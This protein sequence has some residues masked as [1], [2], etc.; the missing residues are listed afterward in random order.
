[1]TIRSPVSSISIAQFAPPRISAGCGGV[2]IFFGSFSFINGAQFEQL[3]RTIAANAVGYA[4]K[5]A[6][7]TMCDPCNAIIGELEK[8]VRELNSLAKNTCAVAQSM[9]EGSIATKMQEQ[10]RKIGT[11]LETAF[12]KA[13]DWLS[14]EN[15][16]QAKSDNS[17]ATGGDS[18]VVADNNPY[19][20]NLVWRAAQRSLGNG[21]NVLSA[22][23]TTAEATEFVMSLFGTVVNGQ[24][25]DAETA[26]CPQDAAPE[27]CVKPV[28]PYEPLITTWDKLFYPRKYTQSGV[29][30]YTCLNDDC[31]KIGTRTISLANWGG[32][33]YII[34]I[35]LF[36]S[37]NEDDLTSWTNNSL[38]GSYYSRTPLE[39]NTISPASAGL[40][41]GLP[42][43]IMTMLNEVQYIK[44][45]PEMIGH[46]LA[47]TLPDY[48]AYQMAVEMLSIGQ[49]AF[50]AQ[51][52]TEMPSSYRANLT[53]KAR[54]LAGLR[55][56]TSGIN[57]MI[58][59]VYETI[60]VQQKLSAYRTRDAGSVGVNR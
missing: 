44:G 9:V 23:L 20:G 48:F 52:K 22:F 19:Y 30:V 3:L 1:M 10:S 14:A 59:A 46:I 37:E 33:Q 21:R 55:E 15:S 41:A 28:T 12:N 24:K 34:N 50:S 5:A 51:T 6:L 32:I 27:A 13:S 57:D 26:A 16:S 49:G 4:I 18:A 42:F 31:T 25:T 60:I 36:G 8:A 45:A 38:I 53:D 2:D 7:K 39:T 29:E 35:A 54:L 47:R 17:T 11:H 43:P 58:K 56:K 40:V